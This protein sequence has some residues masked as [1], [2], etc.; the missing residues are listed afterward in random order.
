MS[1]ILFYDPYKS[2]HHPEYL[3][4]LFGAV[5]KNTSNNTYC[6]L[7]DSSLARKFPESISSKDC[8]PSVQVNGINDS[9]F[10]KL[11]KSYGI[12]ISEYLYLR[13]YLKNKQFDVVVLLYADHIVNLQGLF[14]LKDVKIV[15]L[16]FRAAELSGEIYQSRG[17]GVVALIKRIVRRIVFRRFAKASS[18][19]S[20]LTMDQLL[21]LKNCTKISVC[22]EPL[23]TQSMSEKQLLSLKTDLKIS[24]E[25]VRILLFGGV[26]PRKGFSKFI[27]ILRSSNNDCLKMIQLIVCGEFIDQTESDA[28]QNELKLAEDQGVSVSLM[29]RTIP[30]SEVHQI[31]KVSD[32]IAVPYIGH[33][34]PSA[35]LARAILEKKYVLSTNDGLIGET[36]RKYSLGSTFT[37]ENEESFHSALQLAL[38]NYMSSALTPFRDQFIEENT[39]KNFV[40]VI[41]DSAENSYE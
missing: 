40:R 37:F 36:V 30:F 20:I 2:G 14:P 4:Y 1:R 35:I 17:S 21:N 16:F 23:L 10:K 24:E 41:L 18:T 28:F 11:R 34:G 8:S 25:K 26:V 33:V 39:V 22:P 6:F 19:R 7:V 13:Q 15:G 12:A 31:V 3:H 32:I 9:N 29:D 27:K 38:E 5:A